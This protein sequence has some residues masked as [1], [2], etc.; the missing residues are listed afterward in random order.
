MRRLLPLLGISLLI[1]GLLL[2]LLLGKMALHATLD[3][4]LHNT[5]VVLGS[6]AGQLGLL[7]LVLLLVLAADSLKR[8]ARE[9]KLLLGLLAG[10]GLLL[11]I[12]LTSLFRNTA[13]SIYPPL[14]ADST[15]A[16]DPFLAVRWISL[17]LQGFVLLV[18][19]W[20]GIRLL[21]L[22]RQPAST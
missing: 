1:W 10:G 3:I 20:A 13:F 8:R 17:G 4:Q 6:Y 19:L 2:W 9:S 5:Y 22:V 12:L 7:A 16:A 11:E 15:I 18:I 14:S 21:R